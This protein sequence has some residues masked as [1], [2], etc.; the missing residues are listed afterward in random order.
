MVSNFTV[1]TVKPL[2]GG[3]GGDG[4][5]GE[6]V[7]IV[8]SGNASGEEEGRE[9]GEEEGEKRGEDGGEEGDEGDEGGG[10]RGRRRGRERGRSFVCRG[11]VF[12][13]GAWMSGLAQSLFDVDI[14]SRVSAETVRSWFIWFIWFIRDLMCRD[15]TLPTWL[16]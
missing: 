1:D 7:R 6:G 15:S 2:D 3:N 8:I 12:A 9:G 10:E 13:P 11:A 4:G 14:P 16:E 5:G